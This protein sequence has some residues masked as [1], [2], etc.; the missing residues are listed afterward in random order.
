MTLPNGSFTNTLCLYQTDF[1]M[2]THAD[3]VTN[4]IVATREEI[5]LTTALV[6]VGLVA[7]V[8]FTLAFAGEPLAHEALHDFRHG[9]G[10]TCH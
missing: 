7:A 5:P 10:I 6:A 8:G 2:S 4:R 1:H 9:V 3:T